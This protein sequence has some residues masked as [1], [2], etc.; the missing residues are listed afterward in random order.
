MFLFLPVSALSTGHIRVLLA[1]P[2]NCKGVYLTK[3]D[4]HIKCLFKNSG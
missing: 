1:F 4:S 3:S 2:Y